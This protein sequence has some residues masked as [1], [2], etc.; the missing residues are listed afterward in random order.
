MTEEDALLLMECIREN[1]KFPTDKYIWPFVMDGDK[2][3]PNPKY[4]E[5]PYELQI[6]NSDGQLPFCR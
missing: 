2:S 3:V 1:K 4:E 6:L 5:A